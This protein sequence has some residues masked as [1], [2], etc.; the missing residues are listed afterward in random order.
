MNDKCVWTGL[1][2]HQYEYTIYPAGTQWNDVPG[3]Y[4]F[5][6]RVP[7]GWVA[8]YIGQT[9]SFKNRFD[10]HHK[11][12]CALRNGATH[13]HARVNNAGETSRRTE[14]RDLIERYQ[15]TCNEQ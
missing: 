1:S 6:K 8:L 5:A 13:V 10:D 14:E 3:C 15:P 7:Q 11:W 2:G 4:I 12:P 9:E